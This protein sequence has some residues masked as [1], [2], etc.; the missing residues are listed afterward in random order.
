MSSYSLEQSSIKLRHV[1]AMVTATMHKGDVHNLKDI[2]NFMILTLMPFESQD[3][4]VDSYAKLNWIILQIGDLKR[5]STYSHYQ[6]IPLILAV[7]NY[8][9]KFEGSCI[10]GSKLITCSLWDTN[11]SKVGVIKY[12]WWQTSSKIN[13]KDPVLNFVW[14]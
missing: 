7:M 5:W 3:D 10:N 1:V 12:W 14:I 11:A 8:A 9:T 4:K 13:K 6:I 2:N